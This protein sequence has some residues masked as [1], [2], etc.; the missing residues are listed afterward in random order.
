MIPKLTDQAIGDL[1]LSRGRA[2]LLEEI[3]STPV[4]DET[5][6]TTPARPPRRAVRWVVPLAAAAS[7]AALATSPTWWPG[8]GAT[9]VQ[10]AEQVV[11]GPAAQPA[12]PAQPAQGLYPVLEAA[13]WKVQ[14]LSR[15]G[16]WGE[17]T[18]GR[19]DQQLEVSWAPARYYDDYVR[20]RE[21]ITEP[22]SAGDPVEVLG[23]PG[24]LWAYAATDHTVIREVQDG[25][26][27]ELR[28]IGMGRGAFLELLA[29]LELVDEK[30][31]EA[32]L[33]AEYVTAGERDGEIRR[34]L[35]EIEGVTGVGFPEP[36]TVTSQ[37][38]KPYHL[39][40]DVAGAYA[41]AW[42]D[43]YAAATRSG[44]DEAAEQAARVLGTSRD[45]PVLQWMA[46][47]G[48]YPGA[49]WGYADEVAAGRVPEGYEGGLGC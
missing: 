30:A 1:P 4:L 34:L 38:S 18:W 27:L 12:Q 23:V 10:P 32:T 29:S 15:E 35:E 26:W 45:W 33:P 6:T 19:D 37:E 20:D 48:G 11:G 31:F 5:R 21:H 9:P 16:D 8:R 22:P 39:G 43:V 14:Y 42:L 28:G 46:E 40:A 36:T 13:S 3:M 25:R 24:R 17:I 47:E 44:D 41:C 7:V 2:E 49:V